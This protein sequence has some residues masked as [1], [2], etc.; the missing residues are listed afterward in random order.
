VALAHL[1]APGWEVTWRA[2]PT[3][4]W[5]PFVGMT[6]LTG[7]LYVAALFALRVVGVVDMAM[8]RGALSGSD[9]D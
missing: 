1:A 8:I 9:E 4:G 7:V 3:G 2:L 5:F 6:L